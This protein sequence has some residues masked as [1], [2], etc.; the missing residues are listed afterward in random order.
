[1]FLM[2]CN[3]SSN[4]T[5]A[6]ERSF[7]SHSCHMMSYPSAL[8]AVR[9]APF[10]EMVHTEFGN[11]Q[12]CAFVSSIRREGPH[13]LVISNHSTSPRKYSRD[14]FELPSTRSSGNGFNHGCQ[15][16]TLPSCSFSSAHR[17]GCLRWLYGKRRCT[18]SS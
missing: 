12:N 16:T 10:V 6:T 8:G 18:D 2:R 4:V 15:V 11:F 9:D 13:I 14:I 17:G 1:M 7:V 5:I 3:Y